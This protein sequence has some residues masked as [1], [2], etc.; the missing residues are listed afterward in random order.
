MHAIRRAQHKTAGK[1]LALDLGPSID[2]PIS[3]YLPDGFIP[4]TQLR[5]RLYRRLARIESVEEIKA[6]ARELEDRFGELPEPV[7]GLLYLLRVRVVAAE[8][9]VPA[10]KGNKSRIAIVLPMR[11]TA[12]SIALIHSRYRNAEA[13]GT[14][15]WLTPVDGWQNKLLELLQ[16]LGEMTTA[17]RR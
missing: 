13:R 9:G 15:V 1:A 12:A 3:A 16:T 2:L 14:R 10:I 17:K 11:V 7:K 8:A 4:D 5:L 6:L